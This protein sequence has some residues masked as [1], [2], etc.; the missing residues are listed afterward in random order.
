VSALLVVAA[1]SASLASPALAQA[2]QRGGFA[3]RPAFS[4]PSVPA[5]RIYFSLHDAPGS[6]LRHTVLVSNRGAIPITLSISPVDALTAPISGVIYT[7]PGSPLVATGRWV[8]ADRSTVRVPA[9]RSMYVTFV[10]HVP[11][12]AKPGD[13]VAGLAFEQTG[14]VIRRAV[15]GIEIAVPGRAAPRVALDGL[16]LGGAP[17]VGA[18]VIVT[19]ADTGRDLCQPRLVVSLVRDSG[20]PLRFSQALSTVLPGSV[21]DYP[22]VWPASLHP[23][24]YQV[25]GSAT[26][27]GPAVTIHGVLTLKHAIS[28]ST[29][30]TGVAVAARL[31]K[32]SAG[33]LS[34]WLYALLAVVVLLVLLVLAQSDGRSRARRRPAKLAAPAVPEPPVAPPV[35]EPPPATAPKP[36][37][38]KSD[39]PP[40]A[41]AAKPGKPAA[42]PGKPAAKPPAARSPK[43]ARRPPNPPD[44]E[45][46]RG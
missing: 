3:L 18:A 9:R 13:Y 42:K 27:C 33:G 23:G 39:T 31:E 26:R 46:R 8:R 17:D 12:S 21:I 40:S 14:R 32:P 37:R 28:V 43:T 7:S 44:G 2:A 1:V 5:S 10:V 20:I 16:A 22:F 11:R 36:R 15:E 24:R 6:A 35:P 38:S 30:F 34:G 4:D 45:H 25:A 19:L 29:H 41:R